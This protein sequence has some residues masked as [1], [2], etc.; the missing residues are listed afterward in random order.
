MALQRIGFSIAGEEQ[1]IRGF[2]ATAAEAADMSEPLGQIGDS[3]REA[4]AEQFLT[5]GSAG[6]YGLWKP[7]NPSYERWKREQGYDG[8]ILVRT[9]EMFAAATDTRAVTV[10]PQRMIYEI[11]DP[12]AIHHQR[13]D[14]NLPQRRLVDLNMTVR[15]SWDRIFASWLNRLR[16]GPGW[17]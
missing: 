7:L 3:L 17:R 12:K 2:E 13:G 4:V 5:E 15:R 9:G 11:D 16:R 14:G 6:N 1:Y 10:T 8:G